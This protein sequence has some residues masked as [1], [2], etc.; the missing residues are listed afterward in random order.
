MGTKPPKPQQE[1]PMFRQKVHNSRFDYLIQDP[2]VLETDLTPF[3]NVLEI[4]SIASSVPSISTL[5]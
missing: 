2:R 5:R 3:Q 4:D 1:D